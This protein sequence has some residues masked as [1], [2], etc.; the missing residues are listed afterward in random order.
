M[1]EWKNEGMNEEKKMKE[2][3]NEGIKEWSSKSNE[4]KWMNEWSN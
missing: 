2:R 4:S 3:R 1:N